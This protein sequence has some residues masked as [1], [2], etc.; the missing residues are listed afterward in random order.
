M[1][2]SI[3]N[4]IVDNIVQCEQQNIVPARSEQCCSMLL[5]TL[6]KLFIFTPLQEYDFDVI[7]RPG[8]QNLAD[9][10]SRL[11]TKTPQ[12]N[13]ESSEIREKSFLR[14]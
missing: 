12:R 9:T 5:S 4:S 2:E 13:M 14:D 11:P 10:L 8:V 3:L 7:Y 1:S 6:N